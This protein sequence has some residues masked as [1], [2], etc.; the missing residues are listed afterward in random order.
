M[1]ASIDLDNKIWDQPAK[2]E[3]RQ[4]KGQDKI[5]GRKERNAQIP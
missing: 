1:G 2:E 3:A 5:F 4:N